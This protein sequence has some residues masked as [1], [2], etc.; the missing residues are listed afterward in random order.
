MAELALDVPGPAGRLE[1]L[2]A[3]PETTGTVAVLC[4]PH[5]QH[6]GTMHNKVTHTLAR[7]L[8]QAGLATVRFNFRG[9]Q[10]SEGHYDEGRGE[11][12]DA[13]AVLDWCSQ[14][15][16]GRSL[17][18]AGFSFG[19]LVA[20]KAATQRAVERLITVA[21]P[22]Y[23]LDPDAVELPQCPWLILQG[24]ADEL[25]DVDAVIAWV[26]RVPPGPE[27]IVLPGVDHFFHGRLTELKER[28]LGWLSE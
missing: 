25:V 15:W 19:A 23:R 24:E 11:V 1:A 16:P 10:A 28:L 4:H 3:A 6:G 18:L 7:S 20:L 21:P 8:A 22:L 9:V 2:V 26:N 17:W 13:L 27:L 14:R 12:D 5:P